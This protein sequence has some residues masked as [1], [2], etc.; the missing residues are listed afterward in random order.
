[1]IRKELCL[2][3][4]SEVCEIS[5]PES[6]Q[7]YNGIH[8]DILEGILSC[9]KDRA[10]R[11]GL[12]ASPGGEIDSVSSLRNLLDEVI[13]E[14]DVYRIIIL[15][16]TIL[17]IY[18][19]HKIVDSTKYPIWKGYL[20]DLFTIWLKLTILDKKFDRE[21]VSSKV[22]SLSECLIKEISWELKGHMSVVASHMEGISQDANKKPSLVD[23]W[24]SLTERYYPYGD[25]VAYAVGRITYIREEDKTQLSQFL[26][27]LLVL[28]QLLDDLADWKDDLASGSRTFIT[29]MISHR[30]PDITGLENEIGRYFISDILPEYLAYIRKQ[31]TDTMIFEFH[32]QSMGVFA[33]EMENSYVLEIDGVAGILMKSLE[34]I[35]IKRRS[36]G[37]IL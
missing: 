20:K 2:N 6:G 22:I 12:D 35:G 33:K 30:Y 26:T 13:K 4:T 37:S 11:N 21:S 27:Y 28:D 19:H 23:V 1:M 16:T 15:P 17:Q 9:L 34:M 25:Y 7:L 18:S 36:Q 29:R 24:G 3:T 31:A 32:D 10:S 8:E 14:S 5:V